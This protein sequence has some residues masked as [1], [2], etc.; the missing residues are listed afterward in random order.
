M[1]GHKMTKESQR[2]SE[3]EEFTK[4]YIGLLKG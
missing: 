2:L 4:Q 1:T 3:A